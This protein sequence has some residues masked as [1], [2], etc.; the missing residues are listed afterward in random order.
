[1]MRKNFVSIVMPVF[2][3]N[4][5]HLFK[6]VDSIL[7][8]DYTEIELIV[9]FD[10]SNPDKDKVT[11]SLLEEFKDDHRLKL[12]INKTRLGFTHSLNKGI[13]A[14][15]GKYIGRQDSDDF[16][17]PNRIGKQLEVLKESTIDIV[18]CWS[19]VIDNDGRKIGYLTMP[20]EWADI[21]QNILRH[22]PFTH[23]SIMLT[24][25]LL[26]K[27]GLYRAEFEPSEDYELYLRA[28]SNGFKGEN[29]PEFLHYERW[30]SASLIRSGR[31]LENRVQYIK[32]KIF[33]ISKYG[34]IQPR[35]LLYFPPSL[36]A[37]F[38]KPSIVSKIR[39]KL[40]FFHHNFELRECSV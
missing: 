12:L 18:G 32:C 21:K 5:K 27:I 35:D 28:F 36:F 37:L 24:R 38:I 33:A 17:S 31:W 39:Q 30:H 20:I 29:M 15:K 40:G 1:M 8:Q 22:N 9:V 26:K 3:T 34:Y 10:K 25:C 14:S 2:N 4:P 13:R 6:S 11:L 19:I 16:S 7:S 23:S